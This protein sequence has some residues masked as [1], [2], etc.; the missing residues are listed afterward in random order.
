MVASVQALAAVV[1]LT[2]ENTLLVILM[3]RNIWRNNGRIEFAHNYEE[4]V[5]RYQFIEKAILFS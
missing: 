5:F 3:V 1:T 4:K 2:R